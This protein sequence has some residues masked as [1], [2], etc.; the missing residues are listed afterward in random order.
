MAANEWWR[1]NLCHHLFLVSASNA[2]VWVTFVA[3]VW[4]ACSTISHGWH[5]W[6]PS[7]CSDK[8]GLQ[9]KVT[10]WKGKIW[11]WHGNLWLG[12]FKNGGYW[13]TSTYYWTNLRSEDCNVE[14]LIGVA[15]ENIGKHKRGR[16]VFLKTFR[17][18][19]LIGF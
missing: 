16:V 17:K 13:H 11:K 7:R 2:L 12:I 8:Y 1:F 18:W 3:D 6:M 9:W 19:R 14:L 15:F 10:I 5:K 4:V